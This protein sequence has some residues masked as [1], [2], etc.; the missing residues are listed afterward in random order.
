MSSV[1]APNVLLI[2]ISPLP[3]RGSIWISTRA[4]YQEYSIACEDNATEIRFHWIGR[5]S[6]ERRGGF[7]RQTL[8]LTLGASVK[9]ARAY[10]VWRG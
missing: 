2:A 4:T 5:E 8:G 3:A 7:N 10:P 9:A 1:F 6:G